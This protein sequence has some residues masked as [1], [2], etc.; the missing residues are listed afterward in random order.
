MQPAFPP[1][2]SYGD[3][4][5]GQMWHLAKRRQRPL[6]LVTTVALGRGIAH[7]SRRRACGQARA[8]Q[9]RFHQITQLHISLQTRGQPALA[10]DDHGVERGASRIPH[11]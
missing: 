9:H 10:I 11:H 8:A 5:G 4:H 2:R 7:F 1:R 6:L 3:G